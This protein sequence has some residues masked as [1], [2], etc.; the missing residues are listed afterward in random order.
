MKKQAKSTLRLAGI[1]WNELVGT[2]SKVD[3]S[4]TFTSQYL[5]LETKN[6]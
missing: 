2:S 3:T 1:L 6:K 4:E 5:E